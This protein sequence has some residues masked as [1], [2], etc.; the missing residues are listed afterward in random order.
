MHGTSEGRKPHHPLSSVRGENYPKSL[1]DLATTGHSKILEGSCVC[2]HF[3][4]LQTML[5]KQQPTH[6][7]TAPACLFF[8]KW[9]SQSLR[10]VNSCISAC[11]CVSECPC[12]CPSAF[13]R[14]AVSVSVANSLGRKTKMSTS[15]LI[16][17]L[18]CAKLAVEPSQSS[19]QCV[20]VDRM[21]PDLTGVCGE[22]NPYFP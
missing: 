11:V 13:L 8:S 17:P 21:H 1:A 14:L 9:T 20:C 5:G 22:N 3:L 6:V 4:L 12:C 2:V 15:T 7:D 10:G 18:V 19:Y 16:S